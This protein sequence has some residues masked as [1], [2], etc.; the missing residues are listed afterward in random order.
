MP[1]WSFACGGLVPLAWNGEQVGGVEDAV[2]ARR[3]H[4]AEAEVV[5]R[6]VRLDL[7]AAG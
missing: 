5:V 3:Q 1:S 6:P 2:G 7:G 4:V